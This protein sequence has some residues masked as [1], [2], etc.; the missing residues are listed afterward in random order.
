M[1]PLPLLFKRRNTS[2]AELNGKPLILKIHPHVSVLGKTSL[3]PVILRH[4]TPCISI[5]SSEHSVIPMCS[6]L[7]HTPTPS[8]LAVTWGSYSN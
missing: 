1:S 8:S 5:S 6:S 7:L 2:I 3:H 4:R